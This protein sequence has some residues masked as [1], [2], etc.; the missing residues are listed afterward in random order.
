MSGDGIT[1]VTVSVDENGR[2]VVLRESDVEAIPTD[3]AR[4]DAMTDDDVEAAALAD[5]DAQPMTAE[6]LASASRRPEVERIRS[7]LHLTQE[8]FAERFD[9]PLETLRDWEQGRIIPDRPAR[10]LLRVIAHAPDVVV[11]ALKAS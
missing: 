2:R 3:W 7:G 10:T 4:L 11:D 8:Q 5:P 9:V 6:E 1:R